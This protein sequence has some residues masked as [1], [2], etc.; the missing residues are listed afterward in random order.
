MWSFELERRAAR[1]LR[2][3]R[4]IPEAQGYYGLNLN[5]KS[6]SNGNFSADVLSWYNELEQYFFSPEDGSC[7]PSFRM[8]L[9]SYTVSVLLVLMMWKQK[10]NVDST[11]WLQ[12][13]IPAYYFPKY[14]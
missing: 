8:C 1:A 3:G 11:S 7:W 5:V 9:S 14:C 2:C 4:P 12:G 10:I 13:C 6:N